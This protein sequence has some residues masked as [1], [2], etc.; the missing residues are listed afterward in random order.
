MFIALIWL[1]FVFQSLASAYWYAIWFVEFRQVSFRIR[2]REAA[3]IGDYRGV[4]GEVRRDVEFGK[5]VREGEKSFMV[6]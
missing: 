2:K 1:G 4:L 5:G 3:E 6:V